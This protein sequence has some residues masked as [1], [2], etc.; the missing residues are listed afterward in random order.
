MKVL[1]GP[2]VCVEA[3]LRAP[4]QEVRQGDVSLLILNLGVML[5]DLPAGLH[6]GLQRHVVLRGD[7]EEDADH[8]KAAAPLTPD[9]VHDFLILGVEVDEVHLQGKPHDKIR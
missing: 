5:P 8:R 6:D 3:A 4:G 7:L 9:G 1:S 2:V